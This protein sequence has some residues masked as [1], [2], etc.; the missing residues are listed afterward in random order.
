MLASA[1]SQQIQAQNVTHTLEGFHNNSE[2]GIVLISGNTISRTYNVSQMT[3]YVVGG[4]TFKLSGRYL[5]SN[6]NDVTIS[7]NWA[8]ALR[9]ERDITPPFSIFLGQNI[10][11]DTFA[12][13][14]QQYNS[15]VGG[16]FFIFRSEPFVW[17]F[18][19]GYRYMIENRINRV[20]AKDHLLRLYTEAEHAW[21]PSF[22][23]KGAVEYLPNLTE[24][25]DYKLNGEVS[26]NAA[27]DEFLSLKL[28]YE[29]KYRPHPPMAGIRTTDAQFTLAFVAKY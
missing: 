15:D 26:L 2:A 23:T 27:V 29:V 28:G 5:D 3:S 24:T 17:D 22:S 4:N 18:E 16:K 13:Y 1:L 9:Y 11:G 7:R 19:A 20:Q 8:G 21:T 14:K 10:Q 12:G 6:A 25:D